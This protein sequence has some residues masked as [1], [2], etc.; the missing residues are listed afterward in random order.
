MSTTDAW[1]SCL[2][3][4]FYRTIEIAVSPEEFTF[5]YK[6]QE[7]RVSTRGYLL[8]IKD[9]EWGYRFDGE[10][11]TPEHVPIDLSLGVPVELRRDIS[12]VLAAFLWYGM[13]PLCCRLIRPLLVFKGVD[14]FDTGFGFEYAAFREAG[15]EI[16]ASDPKFTSG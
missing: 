4:R 15:A 13:R 6:D 12:K 1:V 2:R 11:K 3:K 10:R 9:D 8:K 5:R 14:R 7:R 16:G